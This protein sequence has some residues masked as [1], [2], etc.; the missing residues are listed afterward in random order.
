M[1]RTNR[2]GTPRTA[3]TAWK[4]I[5]RRVMHE[6]QS[7]TNCP[8]CQ[9]PLAWGTAKT[10]RSPE[11]DHIT[12]VVLGGTNERENLRV[13]CRECNQKLGQLA[14]VQRR[15]GDTTPTPTTTLAAW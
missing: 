2:P 7:K 6:E 15:R 11:V 4:H 12:P 5:R 1:T 10:P 14:A 9:R 3:T 13:I 8:E